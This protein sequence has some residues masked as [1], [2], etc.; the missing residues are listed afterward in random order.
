[1]NKEE[2]MIQNL[3]NEIKLLKVEIVYLKKILG[4]EKEKK[5]PI[6]WEK[7]ESVGEK[8]SILMNFAPSSKKFSPFS[9]CVT[10]TVIIISCVSAPALESFP[11]LIFLITTNGLMIL[12]AVL[13]W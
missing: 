9:V 8:I 2:I 3:E 1:M 10:M 5:D 4:V 6:A 11:P 12:S 13:L 7:L